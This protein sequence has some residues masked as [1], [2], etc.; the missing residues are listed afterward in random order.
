[1]H[2]SKNSSVIAGPEILVFVSHF[3]VN[4]QP[5]FDC[6][7]PYFK[8]KYENSENIKAD[9]VNTVV[10]NLHQMWAFLGHLVYVFLHAQVRKRKSGKHLK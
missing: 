5:I 9:C 6:F 7:L 3:S 2:F 4:F 1:M 8:L 10:F